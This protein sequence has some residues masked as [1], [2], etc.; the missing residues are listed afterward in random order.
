MKEVLHLRFEAFT[1]VTIKKAVFW[2]V[3]HNIYSAPHPR[4]LLALSSPWS[5]VRPWRWKCSVPPKICVVSEL[6]SVTIKKN[7]VFIM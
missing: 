5:T 7:D 6:Q 3:G 2:D 1:V 4:K